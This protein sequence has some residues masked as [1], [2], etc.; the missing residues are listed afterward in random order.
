MGFI[1]GDSLVFPVYALGSGTGQSGTIKNIS[2]RTFLRFLR[3]LTFRQIR[4]NG[5]QDG[6]TLCC[7]GHR[8]IETRQKGPVKM[9]KFAIGFPNLL[10]QSKAFR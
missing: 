10:Y 5:H 9:L 3:L 2:M 6:S 7:N 8:D 4:R 1:R